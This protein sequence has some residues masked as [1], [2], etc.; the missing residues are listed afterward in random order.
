MD[1]HDIKRKLKIKY[2]IVVLFDKAQGKELLDI[3]I[4]L[5]Y[6]QIPNLPGQK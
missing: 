4:P 2:N 6:G 3:G 1:I 5:A